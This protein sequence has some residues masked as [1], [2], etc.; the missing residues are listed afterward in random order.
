MDISITH[1]LME[2]FEGKGKTED[3]L[4]CL[5]SEIGQADGNRVEILQ[6]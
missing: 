1:F 6:R 2:V 5:F 4:A 3:K